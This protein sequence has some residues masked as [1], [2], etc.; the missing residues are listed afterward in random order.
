M[1]RYVR[2]RDIRIF[3]FYYSITKLMFF[4]D[5]LFSAYDINGENYLISYSFSWRTRIVSMLREHVSFEWMFITCDIWAILTRLFGRHSALIFQVSKEIPSIVIWLE[6]LLTFKVHFTTTESIT[7][8]IFIVTVIEICK[9][10]R[11]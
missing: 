5:W 10:K 2:S 6:A 8:R 7:F 3:Q 4:F 9:R 11:I 1:F